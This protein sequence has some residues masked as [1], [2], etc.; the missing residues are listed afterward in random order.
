M[1]GLIGNFPEDLASIAREAVSQKYS[2]LLV[3]PLVIP[4]TVAVFG[5]KGFKG[6]GNPIVSLQLERFTSRFLSTDE[7][8]QFL[9]VLDD[10]SDVFIDKPGLCK[11][12]MHIIYVT[13]DFKPNRLKAYRIPELL[14]P[15]VA[16]QIQE[17][18]DLGF[19]QPSD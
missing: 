15:D 6:H 12:G 9:P 8:Q 11:V 16:R 14:K 1:A 10:F 13:P 5:K 4:F 18:L 17:L 3:G 7:K 19:I 2:T